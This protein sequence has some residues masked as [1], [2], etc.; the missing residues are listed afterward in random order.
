M[1]EAMEFSISPEE[2]EKLLIEG[3]LERLRLHRENA[4]NLQAA[5]IASHIE[6]RQPLAL[7]NYY[8]DLLDENKHI[9]AR[10]SR[11]VFGP[12]HN[13]P[14]R[15]EIAK[16]VVRYPDAL[17]DYYP[18]RQEDWN[19]NDIFIEIWNPAGKSQDYLLN[20]KGLVPFTN[21]DSD[22]I[23]DENFYQTKDL[24]TVPN[25]AS[26]IAPRTIEMLNDVLRT[27]SLPNESY[28]YHTQTSDDEQPYYPPLY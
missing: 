13:Q 27:D 10:H 2:Q 20:S 17:E 7:N 11:V 1:C 23:A 26:L 5:Q 18:Q 4:Q 3:L 28:A 19:W 21:A 14:T 12:Q 25:P 24:F 8:I 22:V 6:A 16:L 15:H 9:P